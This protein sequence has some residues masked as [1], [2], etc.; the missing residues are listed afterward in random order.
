MYSWIEKVTK[1]DRLL[2]AINKLCKYL[3]RPL[4]LIILSLIGLLIYSCMR[5]VRKQITLHMRELLHEKSVLSIGQT[6]RDYFRNLII[7]LYEIMIDYRFLEG[8]QKGRFKVE[9]DG[10]LDEALQHGRGA[11][12]F[13]PHIGNFFYYYW[14]L[15]KNTL[16]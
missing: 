15:S 13:S 5:S 4:L 10:F 12:V 9:G 3:P 11:I 7:V 16:V 14:Y 1:N 2:L 8:L 6:C